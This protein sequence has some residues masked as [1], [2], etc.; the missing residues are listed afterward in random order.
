MKG[1]LFSIL[2]C[3]AALA[4]DWVIPWVTHNPQFKSDII[5]T[6]PS[7]QTVVID[8]TAARNG[9]ERFATEVS[10]AAH[11]QQVAS[12]DSLFPQLEAGAG[13]ALH[14]HSDSDTLLGSYMVIGTQSASGS[15]PAQG[16][17][18]GNS[19]SGHHLVFPFLP[20]PVVQIAAPVVVNLGETEA[21]LVFTAYQQNQ[22]LGRHN[23][24]LAAGEPYAA[25]A[26][27]L[28]PDLA[29]P[30]YLHV[31]A[32]QPIAGTSFAFNALLEP[33]ISEAVVVAQAPDE[34][35]TQPSSVG[36]LTMDT[37]LRIDGFTM[38]PD[39]HMY[40]AEGWAGTRVFRVHR[41]GLV[42]TAASG[43][44]GPIDMAFDKDGNMIVVE[45][46]GS[47]VRV[48]PDGTVQRFANLSRLPNGIAVGPDGHYYVTHYG[49][50]GSG[51]RIDRV[52]PDGAVSTFAE[53][54]SI[55]TP[56]GLAFDESGLLYS[57]NFRNGPI[58][59][60]DSAGTQNVL[61]TIPNTM[62]GYVRIA[63]D[64]LF[65][66]G[67][68]NNVLYRIHKDSGAWEIIAG[69]GANGQNDGPLLE[70]TFTGT[71]GLALSEDGRDLYITAY[72]DSLADA[73]VRH[74]RL[75]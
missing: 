12:M 18:Q 54:G 52:S 42:E 25:L 39:D 31:Q 22:I 55:Q 56:I 70:A 5:L 7:A 45:T 57:T 44:R 72:R 66:T 62:L 48:S 11:G 37:P 71:W 38:G 34:P 21:N 69:T 73:V 63:G 3:S 26:S 51:R 15:S 58:V 20:D 9:G 29:G 59:T 27:D 46:V 50:S 17:L 28:F 60:I 43:L 10:L 67:H 4:G 19:T 23:Q 13:F 68:T 14:L 36:T 8:V 6:N 75:D 32:D 64:Y 74:V 49:A 40:A 65:V 53:N 33:S 16:N 24:Q 47:L 61:T 2:W 1:L 35:V 30:I 41:D